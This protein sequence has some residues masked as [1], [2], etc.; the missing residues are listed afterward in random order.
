MEIGYSL[1]TGLLF[2]C[3]VFCLLRRSLARLIIGLALIGQAVN[4]MVFAAGGWGGSPAMIASGDK[5][6]RAADA[7]D[8]LPQ[9]LVLTAI[10]IGCGLTAFAAVLAGVAARRLQT[11][12]TADLN[13]TDQL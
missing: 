4:L 8:P 13:H 10:V 1:L 9:A 12:D 3:G 11:F 2:G 5:L 7:A 6:L